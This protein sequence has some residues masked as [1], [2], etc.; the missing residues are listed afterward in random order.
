M[1]KSI[2]D[3]FEIGKDKTVNWFV[4]FQDIFFGISLLTGSIIMLSYG[5][6][7]LFTENFVVGVIL[8]FVGAAYSAIF[9][10]ARKKGAYD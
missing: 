8:T 4:R 1:Y 6:V 2:I 5:I 7:S 3:F 10:Y 9:Y